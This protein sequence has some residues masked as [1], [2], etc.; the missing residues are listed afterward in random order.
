MCEGSRDPGSAPAPAERGELQPA[1]ATVGNRG[2]VTE[3]VGYER[4]EEDFLSRADAPPEEKGQSPAQSRGVIP[5]RRLVVL[6][7]GEDLWLDAQHDILELRGVPAGSQQLACLFRRQQILLEVREH[8]VSQQLLDKPSQERT[9][10]AVSQK[11]VRQVL[12]RDAQPAAG[13]FLAHIFIG[14]RRTGRAGPT[15]KAGSAAPQEGRQLA[16]M[17]KRSVPDQM[18]LGAE[19]LQDLYPFGIALQPSCKT[20]ESG[21]FVLGQTTQRLAMEVR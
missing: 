20:P 18:S 21:R 12:P 13:E 19:V 17:T 15:T 10:R 8:L 7:C 14:T 16:S 6:E 1:S 4:L 2:S 11:S 3:S 5:W 9:A